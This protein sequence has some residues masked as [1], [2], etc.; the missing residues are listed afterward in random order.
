MKKI[1]VVH[2]SYKNIGGE[3][4]AVKS[5]IELLKEKFEVETIIFDNILRNPIKQ[6]FY[7]VLNSNLNSNKLI[8]KKVEEFKPDIVYI[9][10]TWYKVSLGIYQK[11][12]KKNFQVVIKLHNFR[13]F[14]TKN[15]LMKNHILEKDVCYACNAKKTRIFNKYFKNSLLKSLL[16]IYYGKKFIKIIRNEELKLLVLTNF[17]KSFLI[18]NKIRNKN[19]YV[20]R[21]YIE[22]LPKLNKEEIRNN[23][24]YFVYAGRISEEKGVLELIESFLKSNLDDII[25]KIIGDGPDFQYLKNKYESNKIEFLG[26]VSNEE[27]LLIISNS[28]CVVTC[29]KIFEGQP[30]ILCE[31]SSLGIPAIFPKTGGLLEF[32]PSNYELCFTQF[33]YSELE[34]LFKLFLDNDITKQIGKKNYLYYKENFNSNNLLL[35]FEKILNE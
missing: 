24:K 31:A 3:D 5:E 4:I 29:T 13:Y 18:N 35:N 16:V 25:L 15:F 11:L 26:E 9:H 7:F 8:L 21:N 34:D 17:H 1:L 14:C 27:V 2:N 10:N 30:T 20:S 32:F 6:F 12:Y 33:N 22:A 28:I 19:I 23:K